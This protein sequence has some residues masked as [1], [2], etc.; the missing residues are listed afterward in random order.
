MTVKYWQNRTPTLADAVYIDDSALVIG[1]VKI[2]ADSS[3]WPMTV[4]RGD[5]N[6]IR[7]GE[8]TNIQDQSVLHVTH[9]GPFQPGGYAL[10]VGDAVTVGHGVILHGCRIGHSCLV[11]MGAIVMD[12]VEVDDHTLIG[13]GSLVTPGKSLSSGLWVGRPA[14]RVRGLNE[15]EYEQL[16]YSAEHYVKL[17]NSYL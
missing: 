2:G 5:V 17:K 15:S 4:V 3:I 1:D 16:Q 12:G 11:G 10:M 13:A 14:R 6:S 9:D 7:I 8:R